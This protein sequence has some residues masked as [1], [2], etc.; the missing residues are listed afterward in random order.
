VWRRK[1]FV[2]EEG[3]L[4]ELMDLLALVRMSD[5]NDRW[6]WNPGNED[7]FS[8]KSAYVFLDYSLNPRMPMPSLENFVFKFFWKSGVPS[9]KS[10]L[11]WKILLDHVPTRDYL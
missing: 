3:I 4:Q 1:F 5:A 9:M 2:W 10:A 8:V 6:I 7:G 11:S